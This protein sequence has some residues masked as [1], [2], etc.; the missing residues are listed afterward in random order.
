LTDNTVSMV[1][2]LKQSV[3]KWFKDPKNAKAVE[4][5]AEQETRSYNEEE[6]IVM[7]SF[8]SPT[9][10][11]SSSSQ[12]KL[13]SDVLS[14]L[15]MFESY[16]HQPNNVA[17]N[18]FSSIDKSILQGTKVYLKHVLRHPICDVNI[19]HH[20]QSIIR[21]VD[22]VETT[23]LLNEIKDYEQDLCWLFANKEEHIKALEDMLY[24]RVWFLRPLN[25]APTAVTSMNIYKILLSPLIGILS[26]IL[27]FV[28]PYYIIRLRYKI[29]IGFTNYVRLMMSTSKLLFETGGGWTNRLR[30]ISYMFSLI[31][32]FQGIFNSMEISQTMY[33]LNKFVLGRVDNIV[34][35]YRKANELLNRVDVDDIPK[36]FFNADTS[37]PYVALQLTGDLSKMKQQ[38]HWLTTNF[39]SR[40]SFLKTI[41]TELAKTIVNQV[42]MVDMVNAMAR[43]H[44]ELGFGFCVGIEG[45]RPVVKVEEV[46]HPSIIQ[47]TVVRNN[48]RLD[49]KRNAILTGPNAGGKSTLVKSMLLCVLLA[50]TFGVVN[51]RSLALTPFSFINSQ[52]S[53]PDCKGKES[54]FEAEMHRCK[55]NLEYI[56]TMKGGFSFV[57]MDEIF[58][59]TNP[60]EGISGAYA[61]AKSLGSLNSSIVMFTTHYNYLTRLQKDTNRFVNY[62]MD[63]MRAADAGFVFPY[64][65]SKGVSKQYIALDLLRSKGFTDEI[66]DEALRI[67]NKI[68]RV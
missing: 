50:Q 67:K 65:L 32:Y 30:Y 13:G 63:V 41:D 46:W 31:F 59:S 44:H 23:P 66:V 12:C 20:R 49:S 39:G 17:D 16:R 19:M 1:F 42:Y 60:I 26:P 40:L 51:A 28:I 3:G 47:D 36:C 21:S 18:V 4:A 56:R 15:E 68:T 55:Y 25:N 27:Y 54:L 33:K 64:K 10:F 53:I 22:P 9:G 7:S 5:M 43:L 35:F 62:K 24:F 2:N 6:N 29:K 14:D 45:R 38:R 48:L 61:I 8:L 11:Q 52:I 37:F 34:D 58:N 57:I